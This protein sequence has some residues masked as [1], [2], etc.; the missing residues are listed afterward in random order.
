MCCVNEFCGLESSKRIR[1]TS[2]R[3]SEIQSGQRQAREEGSAGRRKDRSYGKGP[4][5]PDARVSVKLDLEGYVCPAGEDV[6]E[7]KSQ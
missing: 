7:I 3:C 5:G 6:K 4:D 2:L 1:K